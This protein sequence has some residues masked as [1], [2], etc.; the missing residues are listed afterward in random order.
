ML[1]GNIEAATG[2]RDEGLREAA[3][4]ALAFLADPEGL[5][6][7]RDEWREKLRAALAKESE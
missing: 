5:A 4:Y 7:K 1:R 3:E 6:H 2:P